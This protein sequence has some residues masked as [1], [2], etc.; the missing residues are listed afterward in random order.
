MCDSAP[1]AELSAG[2][3]AFFARRATGG[4]AAWGNGASGALSI[5]FGGSQDAP[6]PAGVSD[7]AR[8]AAFESGGCALSR[9]GHV[10]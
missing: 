8:V 4:V 5:P 10:S 3:D 2:G 7:V 6:V 9:S 1:I